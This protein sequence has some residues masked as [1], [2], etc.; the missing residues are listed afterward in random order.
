MEIG[1]LGSHHAYHIGA[2]ELLK[3]RSNGQARC[4]ELLERLYQRTRGSG[5]ALRIHVQWGNSMETIQK[6]M[7][8]PEMGHTQ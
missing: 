5:V 8:Y 4:L 7:G 2:D 3:G 1:A 6:W